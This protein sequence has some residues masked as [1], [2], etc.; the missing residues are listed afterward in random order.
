MTCYGHL[1]IDIKD[2]VTKKYHPIRF[3]MMNTDEPR[4]LISHAAS[5]WLGLIK[6]LLKGLFA[7]KCAEGYRCSRKTLCVCVW[8]KVLASG[9]RGFQE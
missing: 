3:Y 7:R 8:G 4:I 1:L 6:V 2:K 5:Y 9:E